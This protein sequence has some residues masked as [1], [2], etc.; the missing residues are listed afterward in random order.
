MKLLAHDCSRP[1]LITFCCVA[2]IGLVIP[3]A[4]SAA[5]N[6]LIPTGSLW[7]YVDNGSDQGT[8][9]RTRQFEDGSW[10]SGR[11]QLGY[12][13]TD[14]QT[15]L[16]FGLNPENKPITYYFRKHFVI[17][18]GTA[19]TTA[20]LRVLRDDG[21]V[22]YLNGTN[23]FRSNMPSGAINY[24][25]LAP[26]N[27]T[28]TGETSFFATNLPGA[29][30]LTGTNLLAVEVHQF[31]TNSGDLSFDLEIL[32]ITSPSPQRP[33]VTRGPYLQQ[34]TP[35]NVIVRWRTD[36][37][38]TSKVWFGTNEANL[39]QSSL[40]PS[41]T[42]EHIVRLDGLLPGTKYFYAIGDTNGIL[43]GDATYFFFTAPTGNPPTRIWV[44]GDSG[45]AND[46]A[47]SVYQAYTNFAGTRYTDLWLMLGDNAY[48]TGTDPQY[49]AAVFDMYPEL[50][51][52]TVLWPTIG[53]HDTAFDS[54]PA[55]T[56][57]YFRIFSLPMNAEAGGVAS[58]TE[59]YYSF[60]Y[61]NIHFV[62]L[63]AMASDRSPDGPMCVWLQEDLAANDKDWLIAYWHHPPYT[64][65]SH[66]SDLEGELIEM[67]ENVVP[68]LE[69]FG[70]D[71]VLCGHSHC[72]ERSFL[73]N[74]HYGLSST[75]DDTMKKDGGSGRE[76]D[77][78]A[79]T[80]AISGPD[81]NEGTVYI[82]AG[83]S[84][85][86]TFG[87]LD[88]PIMY[89]DELELGSLVLDIDG[90]VLNAKFLRETGVIDDYFTIVKGPVEEP[91]Q[92]VAHRPD[93]Q[94]L[95]LTW[96][97]RPGRIY[98]VERTTVL[99]PPNWIPASPVLP[100]VGSSL[101]WSTAIGSSSEHI[102]YRV[103]GSEN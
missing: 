96:S 36:A 31:S 92:L 73:I 24:R 55:P 18:D 71:L 76:D 61:A 37:T 100:A 16:S 22:V 21:A 89:F 17:E 72:Y 35:T 8:A 97:T 95:T 101:N 78:G 98:R 59:K 6:I 39:D 48:N 75:F 94:T 46:N 23:V 1:S 2:L 45:T 3:A 88:H 44:I 13:D 84:G 32:G 51:R 29:L 26:V 4:S 54:T 41:A 62:C 25:T 64:K 77:T 11:A 38:A 7:R 85:Q 28:G 91:L 103:V 20:R 14:E 90:S 47:R 15:T 102:F 80:K 66:D 27:V 10:P 86:A 52:Q 57:P 70:V 65:G 87:N 82:V 81:A 53:N 9:W 19:F 56:I 79:Y 42:N 63:D 5:T 40:S 33:T 74:G 50:L 60:D 49:Q 34:G 67:R 30:L 58:G 99:A 93:D 83:S 43:A 12:G 69:S 68:I